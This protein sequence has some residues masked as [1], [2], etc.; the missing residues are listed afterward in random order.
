[1]HCYS[2]SENKEYPGELSTS[3]AKDMITDL[4]GFGVPVML[5]SGGE[6]FLRKDF[7]ELLEF[8]IK[9]GIG[10]VISTNGTCIN[11]NI[12]KRLKELG[13]RYVGISL[14][15]IGEIN[16][17]FRGRVG[18]FE[19]AIAG[20]RACREVDQRV[21]LR[22]TLTKSNYQNI[23]QIFDFI[24]EEGIN[25]AC[26]YHLVYSG[27]GADMQKDDLTHAESRA[28]VDTII[29]RA[30]KF[31][32]TGKEVEILT[33]DNHTDAVYLYKRMLKEDPARAKEVYALLKIN[34]GNSSGIGWGCIDNQGDV[35]ADQFFTSYSFGNVKSRKFS[36]IWQDTGDPVMKILKDRKGKIGGKC[37][38]CHYFEI[39]NGNFRARAMAV[40]KD[41]WAEDPAC[42]ISKEE[43]LQ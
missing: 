5:F 41:R 15:G 22:L 24:E 33:V 6:P 16:D 31:C 36:E 34:G 25:R 37:S 29:N 23:N 42:Y 10:S 32:E 8:A 20:F 40:Y 39:C 35:H 28:V 7:F 19:E 12:A 17:K 43:T 4:A 9:S 21:G 14:D 38:T 26:F 1:V 11:K 30:Q 18:A 27:R 2:D 3:E 13:V